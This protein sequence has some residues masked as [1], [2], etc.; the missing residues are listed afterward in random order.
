V[1]VHD[2]LVGRHGGLRVV[3]VEVVGEVVLSAHGLGEL[4]L[5]VDLLA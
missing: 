2:L 4:A 5:D 3:K 1:L